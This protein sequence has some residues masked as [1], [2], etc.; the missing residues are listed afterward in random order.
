MTYLLP[1]ILLSTLV[2]TPTAAQQVFEV[3]DGQEFCLCWDEPQPYQTY[4]FYCS[5]GSSIVGIYFCD[6]QLDPND[7]LFLMGGRGRWHP[8][9][10]SHLNGTVLGAH[11]I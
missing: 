9:Y 10:A 8:C 4:T 3:C 5:E 1:S 6:A 2:F 7:N 11:R